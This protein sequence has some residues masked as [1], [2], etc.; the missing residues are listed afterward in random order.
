M[1]QIRLEPNN[2]LDRRPVTSSVEITSL[3][4]PLTRL[5][6]IQPK[7]ADNGFYVRDLT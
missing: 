4:L 7:R 5:N 6:F 2:F 1:R 3:Y